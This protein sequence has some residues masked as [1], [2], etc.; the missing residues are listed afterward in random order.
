MI[1][2]QLLARTVLLI[3]VCLAVANTAFALGDTC[4]NVPIKLT[5]ATNVKIKVTK[6]EYY[7]YDD[8]KWRTEGMFGA[9]GHKNLQP[10]EV[11]SKT[12]DLEH[13]ENDNTKFKV[14]YEENVDANKAGNPVAETTSD[15]ICKDNMPTKE[16]VID[17]APP[18]GDPKNCDWTVSGTVKVETQ[19]EELTTKFGTQIPL[20][21]ISVKVSGAT[22]GF[23]DSWGTVSTDS[24]GKF[25]ITKEKSC[26]DR[27]L[28][29][30]V[31]FENDNVKIIKDPG[32]VPTTGAKWYTIIEDSDRRRKAG[33]IQIVPTVFAA[34]KNHDL[35]DFD[36]RHH[37]D[38]WVIANTLRDHVASFGSAFKFT[39]R[40]TIEY[41][42]NDQLNGDGQEGS[43]TNPA[44]G[45][46]HI[47]VSNDGTV[48]HLNV[49]TL[50]HEM[51]HAWAFQHVSG[52]IGTFANLVTSFTTHCVNKDESVSFHE[53]FAE[54]A[55]EKLKE[56][57]F[58]LS[59]PTK[60]LP[61]N[62]DALN[63]GLSC[64]GKVNKIT[65]LLEIEQ[66]EFGWMSFLRMLTTDSLAG[67]TYKGEASSTNRTDSSVF[68][69]LE[70][71]KIV[72]G[73]CSNPTNKSLKNILDVF[74]PHSDKGFPKN[75]S[76]GDMN[77]TAFMN[78]AA[79]ILNFEDQKNGLT[80]ILDPSKTTEPSDEI[81]S[82]TKRVPTKPKGMP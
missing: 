4:S 45:D 42:N 38:I 78:R 13:I 35:S 33:A 9:D 7:D 3:G 49:G 18:P 61:F 52:E 44:T 56:E 22:I 76:N 47:F 79:K 73:T 37:A 34:G 16:V 48:D 62:R 60:T 11:F 15:F 80:N 26:E 59:F 46:V 81:C 25:T 66:H 51:M 40:T 43:F 55:S 6:F 23:F 24:D 28:K 20:K 68:I 63:E 31:Q 77:V 67:F 74:L 14:T 19:E 2:R 39:K 12:Q 41:P 70:P 5:N 65:N 10:G 75:I 29:I 58:P 72:S 50:F 17:V 53:G 36:A 27:K 57:I 82:I 21:G 54:F 64:E 8:Q 30:E 69:S 32:L 71:K 1:I